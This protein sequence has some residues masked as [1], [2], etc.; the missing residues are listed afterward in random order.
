M[1]HSRAEAGGSPK[2]PDPTVHLLSLSF[3]WK[4]VGATERSRG[5]TGH[6]APFAC[7]TDVGLEGVGPDTE[8]RRR[9]AASRKC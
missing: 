2:L 8:D 4:T 3:N 7:S 6:K 5:M 9:L 1:Q